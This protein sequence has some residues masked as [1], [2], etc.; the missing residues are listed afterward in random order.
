MSKKWASNKKDQLLFENFK[1]F[2]EKGDFRP[3]SNEGLGDIATGAK[4]VFRNITGLEDLFKPTIAAIYSLIDAVKVAKAIESG[5]LES[6]RRAAVESSTYDTAKEAIAK[7]QELHDQMNAEVGPFKGGMNKAPGF[8][9]LYDESSRFL[10]MYEKLYKPFLEDPT[11]FDMK[12]Q[13]IRSLEDQL[14]DIDKEVST[15]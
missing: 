13:M 12:D 4:K 10:K 11:G 3:T 5:E 8:V 6:N 9:V 7:A 14:A 15:L 1:N 2:M